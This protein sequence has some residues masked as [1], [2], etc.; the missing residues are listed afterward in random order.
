MDNCRQ[1]ASC[2][3]RA[4]QQGADLVVLGECITSVGN[5][6]SHVEAA[7]PVPG[8]STDYLAGLAKQNSIYIVTSLHERVRHLIYNTAVLLGP[9][10]QLVGKYRKVCP[11]RDEYR[12]G[13]AAGRQYPVFDTRFG[14]LGMMIC[15]DVQRPAVPLP[16]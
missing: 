4:A 14:K 13:V 9:E 11:A 15:F 5:G 16:K 1:L 10:G 8:P 7:E 3:A 12:K 6:L 2:V